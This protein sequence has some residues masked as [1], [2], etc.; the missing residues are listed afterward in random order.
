MWSFHAAWKEQE[1]E[2]EKIWQHGK[3]IFYSD[4][5]ASFRAYSLA[6]LNILANTLQPLIIQTQKMVHFHSSSLL[7]YSN[8]TDISQIKGL[9]CFFPLYLS[10]FY[11][12]FSSSSSSSSS[13]PSVFI[14]MFIVQF[15][16]L[17]VFGIMIMCM[18]LL[19]F[20]TCPI[21]PSFIYFR[22]KKSILNLNGS[23]YDSN[24]SW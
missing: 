10:H 14:L 15:Q 1:E 19:K 11:V 24:F 7:D 2:R 21:H 6:Y 13:S 17:N 8:V 5:K 23:I 20:E 16:N 4:E 12:H 3:W 9:L 22:N 18:D